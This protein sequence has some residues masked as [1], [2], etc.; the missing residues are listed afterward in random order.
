MYIFFICKKQGNVY[1]SYMIFP[2]N[3]WKFW[4]SKFLIF[5]KFISNP[6]LLGFPGGLKGKA[7]ACNAGDPGSIPE[8]GRS[9]GEGNGT[10]LQYSCLE[11]P[12]D[13]GAWEAAVHGVAKSWT[14]LSD[15]TS[16]IIFILRKNSCWRKMF[17]RKL[18]ASMVV[19]SL[20][21]SFFVLLKHLSKVIDLIFRCFKL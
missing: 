18:K 9:P 16:H 5:Q 15:F 8:S 19:G 10:P 1:W 11:N 21:L 6:I 3:Y 2:M 17:T 20:V 12:M 14:R 13:G 7:S 4:F